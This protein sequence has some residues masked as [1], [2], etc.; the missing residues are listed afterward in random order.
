MTRSS[1]ADQIVVKPQN[2]VYTGLAAT[3]C[4]VLIL[5]LVALFTSA[6]DKFGDGLLMPSG[7]TPAAAR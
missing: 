4:V 2:D 3:A 1:R 6:S 5:G 7:A